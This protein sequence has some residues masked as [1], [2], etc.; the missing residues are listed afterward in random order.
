MPQ[1]I[2]VC[3]EQFL[4]IAMKEIVRKEERKKS[5]H[6]KKHEKAKI[7]KIFSR[8]LLFLFFFFVFEK[9]QFILFNFFW[10]Q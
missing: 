9:F 8:S 5:K 1:V 6:T 7:L 2:A 3:T 10:K 4:C